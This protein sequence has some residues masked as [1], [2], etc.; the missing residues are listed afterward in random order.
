MRATVADDPDL[1]LIPQDRRLASA[2]F[3]G[4][5]LVLLQSAD[6][7]FYLGRAGSRS[8]PEEKRNGRERGDAG[9]GQRREQ[10]PVEERT[11]TDRIVGHRISIIACY[12][13]PMDK[14]PG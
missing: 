9:R 10:E 13:C 6:L 12:D 4:P 14:L 1:F 5:G 3:D 8:R 11:P 7:D 2:V